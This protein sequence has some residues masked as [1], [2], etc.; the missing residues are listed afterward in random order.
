[1]TLFAVEIDRTHDTIRWV[2]A[3][4][5]PALLYSPDTDGFTDLGG[6][7]MVLGVAKDVQFRESVLNNVSPGSIIALGTDGIWEAFNP[8][9]EMFG[10]HQFKEIIRQNADRSAA[11]ILDHVYQDIHSFTEGLKPQDDITLVILKIGS[12]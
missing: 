3:G 1:M 2:R 4:H 5:D 11:T 12:A 10:K 9:G 6:P 8:A 7:G